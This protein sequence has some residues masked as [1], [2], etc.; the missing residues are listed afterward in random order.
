M[1]A[2]RPANHNQ[3]DMLVALHKLGGQA[4][5]SAIHT[6]SMVG[7]STISHAVPVLVKHG[8]VERIARIVKLTDVG[9]AAVQLILEARGALAA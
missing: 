4:A 3:A 2:K 1:I 9:H 7:R 8:Y 5:I 6:V